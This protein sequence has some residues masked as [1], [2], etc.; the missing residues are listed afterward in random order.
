VDISNG[1]NRVLSYMGKLAMVQITQEGAARPTLPN[2]DTT[3][4]YF[5]SNRE[6]TASNLI[7]QLHAHR[8]PI[9]S[10]P[11][12]PA[13]WTHWDG[14]TWATNANISTVANIMPSAWA[15]TTTF[16]NSA[17]Y[18][19]D[20]GVF[21]MFM[22]STIVGR[23][24]ATA[25]VPQGPWTVQ[26]TITPAATWCYQFTNPIIA[27]LKEKKYGG[28]TMPMACNGGVGDSQTPPWA[29]FGGFMT[30]DFSPPN[31]SSGMRISQ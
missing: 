8:V 9:A 7:H 15:S 4:E 16:S 20:F 11:M 6:T 3:Y 18:A 31:A 19:K 22:D 14:S 26:T 12:N 30:M 17:F 5:L 1:A 13:N 21:V 27:L 2:V 23:S 24:W 25:S 29:Y 28:F 10:D